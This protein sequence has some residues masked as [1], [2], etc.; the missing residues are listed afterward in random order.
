MA[1]VAVASA[2]SNHSK[3]AIPTV[4]VAALASIAGLVAWLVPAGSRWRGRA[5][6]AAYLFQPGALG[7][8]AVSHIFE[9]LRVG[10]G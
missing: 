2:Q 1:V 6:V 3:L 5:T 9:S 4:V 8:V 7:L 10:C